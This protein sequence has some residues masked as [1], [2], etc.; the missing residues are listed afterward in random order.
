M[1]IS[2]FK[3]MSEFLTAV[4][5]NDHA[6]AMELLPQVEAPYL[7]RSLHG[8]TALHWAS[9]NN[10]VELI[11]ILIQKGCSPNDKNFRGTAP[12][13]YSASTNAKEACIALLEAGADPRERSGFSGQ[14]PDDITTSQELCDILYNARMT[15]EDAI[16]ADFNLNLMYRMRRW[17]HDTLVKRLHQDHR[18]AIQY[19]P[20]WEERSDVVG[21]V[22]QIN[23]QLFEE[24]KLFVS[25]LGS[26]ESGDWHPQRVCACCG[27]NGGSKLRCSRC[28]QAWFCNKVCQKNAWSVHKVLNCK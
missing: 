20:E 18:T 26:W 24:W 9:K 13:Y 17:G 14:Y 19:G 16:N 12:L 4:E 3:P 11:T 15:I 1:N 23:A 2:A 21:D 22:V 25:H 8:E 7:Y 5:D 6:K 10:D 27:K 28:K